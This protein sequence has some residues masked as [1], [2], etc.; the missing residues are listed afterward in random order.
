MELKSN[1]IGAKTNNMINLFFLVDFQQF[2]DG[3]VMRE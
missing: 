2:D 3:G 1:R